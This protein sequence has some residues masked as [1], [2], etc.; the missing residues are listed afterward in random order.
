[1]LAVAVVTSAW[2]IG[3]DEMLKDPAE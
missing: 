1:M 2:A 3:P